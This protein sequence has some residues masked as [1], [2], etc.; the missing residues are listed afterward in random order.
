MYPELMCPESL[1]IEL[2]TIYNTYNRKEYI[3]PD[4]LE[5]VYQYEST[6]DREISGL[7]AASLAYGNVI[8]ILKSVKTVLAMMDK[9]PFGYL[10]KKTFPSRIERDLKGFRHRFATGEHMAALMKGIRSVI[11]TWGSLN[12]CFYHG[13]NMA[14]SSEPVLSAMDFFVTSLKAGQPDCGHLL[15]V[16]SKGSACKRLNL[17]FRWMVRSDAVDPGV[18]ENIPPSVLMIPLDTH[19]HAIGR[20][21]GFTNRNQGNMKTAIEIRDG[22]RRILPEDPVKYDF[23]LTR[24]GIRRELNVEDIFNVK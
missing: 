24:F 22:F 3:H 7:I 2:E 8:Q 18:W 11:D 23:S 20:R 19:M 5:F 1:K 4:P 6:I 16:P 12:A 14:D 10:E 21:L 17:Y 9:S 15:P 13:L